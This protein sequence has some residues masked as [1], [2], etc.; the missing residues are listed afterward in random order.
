VKP[1]RTFAFLLALTLLAALSKLFAQ[2]P[3]E[4]PLTVTDG[5]DNLT[6][7]F[8]VLPAAHFCIDPSDSINGHFEFEFPPTPP[9]GLQ[10]GFVWPRSSSA[11]CFGMGS[12]NDYRPFTNYAQRDTFRLGVWPWPFH[13]DSIAISWPSG[14]S[15]HFQYLSAR[16]TSYAGVDSVD[17]LTQTSARFSN[18]DIIMMR[19]YSRGLRSTTN[20]C[21][22]PIAQAWIEVRNAGTDKDT[23]WFGF[24]STATC[25]EDIQFCEIDFSE[26]CGPP[27]SNFLC[28]AW[29]NP[30]GTGTPSN[31]WMHDIRRYVHRTQ[32]DIHRVTFDPGAP[33]YPITFRWDRTKIVAMCDSAVMLIGGA[34]I[35]MDQQDSTIISNLSFVQLIRYGQKLVTSDVS[36][37]WPGKD[38][39]T[40]V[41]TLAQN[42]PNPFN[43][44]TTIHYQLPFT[45]RVTI[46][47]SNVLGQIVR[48]LVDGIEDA[49]LRSVKW[50]GISETGNHVAGGVYFYRIETSSVRDASKSFTQV[51]KMLLL[52]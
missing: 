47:L 44:S 1:Q 18:N 9:N 13:S 32:V 8:G 48:T 27:G 45:S 49:G 35:R 5:E 24:D 40:A 4:V 31:V 28:M 39:F 23:L 25:G 22:I 30:C 51:K 37:K 19:I 43:P 46:K 42:Y 3:F 52:R 29:V 41:Y 50:N 2:P 20:T 34:R 17:M 7:Y 16:F 38:G 15:T 12:P 33:G 10:A 14:L 6:S 36:E 26:P 11:H 21:E